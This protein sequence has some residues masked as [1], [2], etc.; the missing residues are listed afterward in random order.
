VNNAGIGYVEA[1]GRSSVAHWQETIDINLVGALRIVQAF[2]PCLLQQGAGLV[3]NVGSTGS[4]GW[5][6]LTLYAATKAALDAAT[7]AVDR[8]L[9][10]SGVRLVSVDIGPTRG[11]DFGSRI[12]DLEV[13]AR[14]TATWTELGIPWDQFATADESA[15]KILDAITHYVGKLTAQS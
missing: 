3:V 4:S 10:G 1:F 7:I 15:G 14:A 5:P 12:T 13:L 11:T 9:S 8:E 2:L 6:Y